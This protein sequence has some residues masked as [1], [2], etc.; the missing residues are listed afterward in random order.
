M[1]LL[2][3]LPKAPKYIKPALLPWQNLQKP[4]QT[5]TKCQNLQKLHQTSINVKFKD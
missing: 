5:S 1:P 4:H 3:F 2:N